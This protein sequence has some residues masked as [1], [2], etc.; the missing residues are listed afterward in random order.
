MLD[1]KLPRCSRGVER[2]GNP[3]AATIRERMADR[4]ADQLVSDD[5]QLHAIAAVAIPE[6][7]CR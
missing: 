2:D 4:I 6:R 1:A 3:A 5:L 7:F